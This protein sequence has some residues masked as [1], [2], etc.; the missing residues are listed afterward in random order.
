MPVDVQR[1]WGSRAQCKERGLRSRDGSMLTT[2]RV[3]GCPVTQMGERATLDLGV[4]C[5]SPMLGVER[6][7]KS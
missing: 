5:L 6:T 2:I 4:L 1:P 7:Q 3:E